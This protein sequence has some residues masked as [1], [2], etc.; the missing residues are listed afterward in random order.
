MMFFHDYAKIQEKIVF[1]CS[2]MKNMDKKNG[3][4]PVSVVCGSYW[5]RTND[6]LLVRQVL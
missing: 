5:I 1:R 2:L 4:K 6:P 3:N